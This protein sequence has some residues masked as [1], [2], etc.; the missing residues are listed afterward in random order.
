MQWHAPIVSSTIIGG[1]IPEP[2]GS[3][4]FLSISDRGEFLI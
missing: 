4:F 1:F 3:G 2:L